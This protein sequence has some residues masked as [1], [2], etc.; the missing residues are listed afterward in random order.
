MGSFL[1]NNGLFR[2]TASIWELSKQLV[3]LTDRLTLGGNLNS[4][5]VSLP[6][7]FALI[8]VLNI[9]LF[10]EEKNEI[11]SETNDKLSDAHHPHVKCPTLNKF[12]IYPM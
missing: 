3:Y 12:Y 9:V 6:P 10:F 11:Q 2:P 1:A 7:F 5:V 4:Q 8:F